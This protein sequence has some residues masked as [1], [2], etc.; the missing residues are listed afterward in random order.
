MWVDGDGDAGTWDVESPHVRSYALGRLRGSGQACVRGLRSVPTA[1][2]TTAAAA[3]VVCQSV[4]TRRYERAAA[5]I[6]VVRRGACVRT[7]RSSY[8]VVV[9]A[10]SPP[11]DRAIYLLDVRRA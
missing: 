3:A 7:H 5:F 6:R 11:P 10:L 1:R 2:T 4:Q 8:T 9:L